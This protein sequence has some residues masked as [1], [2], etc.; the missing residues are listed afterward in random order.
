MMLLGIIQEESVCLD[1][2]NSPLPRWYNLCP[3]DYVSRAIAR[4]AISNQSGQL[5][6]K[7]G[8]VVA[9]L[10][11]PH[12]LELR[13]IVDYLRA[14]GYIVKDLP[15]KDFRTNILK[16]EDTLH[17]F[18]SLKALLTGPAR[19]SSPLAPIIVVRNI[20]TLLLDENCGQ[21]LV[22]A[23]SVRK[24]MAFLRQVGQ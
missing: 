22:S 19:P 21:P 5:E 14:A 8:A 24:S 18:F 7:Q 4:I 17:P 12:A 11:A 20:K 9:H 3:V 10:C 16:I 1:I 15:A 6:K 23:R 2:Y 13:T